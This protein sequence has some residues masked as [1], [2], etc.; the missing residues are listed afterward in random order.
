MGGFRD[1]GACDLR[2][3][4]WPD[5]MPPLPPGQY[6]ILQ[7]LF[8]IDSLGVSLEQGLPYPVLPFMAWSF[9][10]DARIKKKLTTCPL[11]LPPG[12]R[13][14]IVGGRVVGAFSLVRDVQVSG[15]AANISAVLVRGTSPAL[16]LSHGFRGALQ[17][18]CG[19]SGAGWRN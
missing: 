19:I 5:E 14:G 17:L 16:R 7:T 3:Q 9:W 6:R 15:A 10:V 2:L 12:R 13:T 11:S 4:M 1:E 18:G 8:E